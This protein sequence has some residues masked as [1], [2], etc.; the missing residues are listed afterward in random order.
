MTNFDSDL[1][2]YP[3]M[4]FE[5]WNRQDIDLALTV[6]AETLTWKDPLLPAPL[7]SREEARTFFEFGWAAFPDL[8]FEALGRP[9]IDEGSRTVAQ[10]WIM[11]GT[12]SGTGFAPGNPPSGR[13]FE[14]PGTDVW[15]LD[16]DGVAQSV[17]AY[18]DAALLTRQLDHN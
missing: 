1:T 12:D 8:K 5:A 10:E 13:S 18:W 6:V 3:A 2:R 11:R 17:T 14:I 7:S 15:V 9:L 4:Y 16:A